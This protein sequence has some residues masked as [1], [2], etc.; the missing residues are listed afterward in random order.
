MN[1]QWVGFF[2]SSSS[3][4]LFPSVVIELSAEIAALQTTVLNTRQ[5]L[6]KSMKDKH[7]LRKETSAAQA[8]EAAE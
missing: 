6:K 4:L 5:E 2:F 3:S 1:D 7:F 8:D